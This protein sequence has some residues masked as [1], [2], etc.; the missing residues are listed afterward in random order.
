[1]F[2]ARA[3]EIS[4]ARMANLTTPG[5]SDLL[6]KPNHAVLSTLNEDGS[7]HNAVVWLNVEGDKVAINSARGRVWPTNL[8]RDPR[9]NLLVINESNPY[10]Y[11]EIK[12]TTAEAEGGD[13]HIDTLA[14]K[15]LDQEKYPWRAEG[16]ERVKFRL[17]PERVRY[18]KA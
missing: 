15:Y 12:G 14:Q 18:A 7:V 11:V 17:T 10:E 9:A 8:E 6:T 4:S 1:L 3:A 16:E 13:E 5:V 2:A